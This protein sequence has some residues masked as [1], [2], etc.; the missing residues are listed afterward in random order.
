MRLELKCDAD[1]AD[2]IAVL[3]RDED[4][5]IKIEADEACSAVRFDDRGKVEQLRDA[6]SEWLERNV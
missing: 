5:Y 1:E 6:L 2:F 3:L 4:V